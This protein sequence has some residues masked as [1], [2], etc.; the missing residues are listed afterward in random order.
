MKSW[1]DYVKKAKSPTPS[2]TP[3]TNQSLKETADKVNQELVD[4][5]NQR[6]ANKNVEY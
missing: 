6:P 4:G 1:I 5:L 2:T 3:P